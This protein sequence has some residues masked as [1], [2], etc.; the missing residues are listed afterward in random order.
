MKTRKP[1]G[2]RRQEIAEAVLR[3]IGDRGITALTTT[4]LATEVGLTSGALFRHFASREEILQEAVRLAMRKIE[5]TFPDD[6]LPP[7]ERLLNLAENRVMLLGSD[8]GLAWLL[9][10]EQAFLELPE[11]AVASLREL[12]TRSK[13]Y[14]LTAIREGA[15]AGS[16]RKD[17][18]P[19]VLLVTVMG[20]VH[21][22]IGIPGMHG[23]SGQSRKQSPGQVL[24]ALRRLLA[25]PPGQP[26]NTEGHKKR[27]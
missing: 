17:I 3:I 14:L 1:T 4:T 20:T 22:L 23:H 5:E 13:H 25:P 16:I 26:G 21:A 15:A 11:A 12:V 27:R 24:T 8:P 18:E 7:M 19:E 10:S 2:E 9:R 6:S